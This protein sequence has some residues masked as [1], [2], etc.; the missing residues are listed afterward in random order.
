MGVCVFG[1]GD[2]VRSSRNKLNMRLHR[3]EVVIGQPESA[4][5]VRSF[6]NNFNMCL[7]MGSSD[8]TT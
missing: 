7:Q 5:V 8:R 2:Q 6:R 1:M 3:R 4:E